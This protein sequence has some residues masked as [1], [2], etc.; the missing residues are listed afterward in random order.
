[1][2][3][4]TLLSLARAAAGYAALL[5]VLSP[6]SAAQGA[7]RA[8]A[9]A[10][11]PPRFELTLLQVPDGTSSGT[12]S[13]ISQHG[14]IAGIVQPEPLGAELVVHAAFWSDGAVA[15][16]LA[17]GPGTEFAQAFDIDSTG[18][19][20]GSGQP[21]P[22]GQTIPFTWLAG[23]DIEPVPD[24]GGVECLMANGIND[25]GVLVGV[26]AFPEAPSPAQWIQGVPQELPMLPTHD[27][28][29]AVAISESGH[30]VGYSGGPFGPVR[31]VRWFAGA[32]EE[33]EF[34]G[35]SQAMA[36]DV[37]DHGEAVGDVMGAGISSRAVYWRGTSGVALP[38][39]GGTLSWARGINNRSWIV[40]SAELATPTGSDPTMHAALWIGEEVHDLNALTVA[41]PAGVVLL[42]AE[43]VN[44]A[45]QI[46]GRADVGGLQRPFLLERVAP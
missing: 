20:V 43:A 17:T 36:L 29:N 22:P 42:S 40:G 1:M 16:V 34:P 39:L 14:E 32:V 5:A 11:T 35:A 4:G 38:E 18:L 3:H 7:A 8:P 26:A 24:A 12:A 44:D 46:V 6:D 37:N 27:F 2:L 21:L 9:T 23:Q 30:V 19:V 33:L 25:R 10:S 15:P 28:G 41:L 13:A 45:G 31:A